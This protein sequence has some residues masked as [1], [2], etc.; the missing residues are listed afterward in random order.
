MREFNQPFLWRMTAVVAATL[1]LTAGQVSS[2]T[3]TTV[4]LQQPLT[5]HDPSGSGQSTQL[6][7]QRGQI[8][9]AFSTGTYASQQDLSNV[10]GGLGFL[11]AA[12]VPLVGIEGATVV[13]LYREDDIGDQIR[14]DARLNIL[15]SQ[16]SIATEGASA[17]TTQDI[18]TA[19]GLQLQGN[20]R[21]LAGYITGGVANISDIR[22]DLTHGHVIADINGTR[23]AIGTRPTLVVN[24][25]NTLLWTFDPVADVSGAARLN[26]AS[27][28]SEDPVASLRADGIAVQCDGPAP[29]C[30]T[31][32]LTSEFTLNNLA[33]TPTGVQ[34]L[35]DSLGVYSVGLRDMNAVNSSPGKWGSMRITQVFSNVPEPSTYAL[36]GL[37]LV[38]IAL[39]S[40]RKK[41]TQPA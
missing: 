23:T 15:A 13:D 29:A 4:L 26:P 27:L 30:F 21:R 31:Y 25:P 5:I 6:Y 16:I 39:A 2:Q 10:G 32:Q 7:Y 14:V 34:R 1:L 33:M 20:V 41:F 36:M 11:N 37:G 18:A 3:V 24:S 9:L 28:L 8:E 22:V 35:S 38:G 12:V 19:G 17:G 40:R